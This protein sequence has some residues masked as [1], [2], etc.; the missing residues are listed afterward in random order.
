MN[1]LTKIALDLQSPNIAV[2]AAGKQNDSMS[3]KIEITLKDG[4]SEFVP[5][6]DSLCET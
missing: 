4:S 1:S 3:R 2:V 6:H 5:P